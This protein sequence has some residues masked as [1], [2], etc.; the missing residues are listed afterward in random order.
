MGHFT[1][2]RRRLTLTVCGSILVLMTACNSSVSTPTTVTVTAPPA[3]PPSAAQSRAVAAP[4]APPPAAP[5]PTCGPDEATALR[6]ALAKLPPEPVTGRGWQNTPIGSD[7]NPCADL[8]TILV[9]IQGGTA[10]SPVQALMFHRGTY[11][12]TGTSKA[13]GFTSV[14]A[15]R[16]TG[17]TVVLDYATPG[18]CDA[19][20]PAAV[21]S[22]RYQWQGDHVEMLDP[23]PP[24]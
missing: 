2:M 21:T 8:S 24:S 15:A 10:S 6:S 7:Y 11:L 9:M 13:Y 20:A 5:P 3:V 23:A 14:N 4:T 22:V 18:E 12:G 16:S 1:T 17:D 19:C